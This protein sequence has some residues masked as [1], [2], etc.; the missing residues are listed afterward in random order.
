MR[1][2]IQAMGAIAVLFFMLGFGSARPEVPESLKAPAGEEVILMAHATGVQIYV[3]QAET[4]QKSAW[5]L[6]AP[7]AEL[8]DGTGKQIVHHFAGPAWKHIDESEVTGK[9]VAKQ[10]APKPDAIPWLLLSAAFTPG[11]ERWPVLRRF[12]GSAARPACHPM[13]VSAMCPRTARSRG[14]PT[15]RTTIST[16][17]LSSADSYSS[18]ITSRRRVETAPNKKDCGIRRHEAMTTWQREERHRDPLPC[19][20]RRQTCP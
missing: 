20:L 6:K 11:K 8:S 10:D 9:V 19:R 15:P 18:H 14:A 17:R 13:P 2:L 4:E 12:N 16:R 7:E 3:C 5:V 1:I